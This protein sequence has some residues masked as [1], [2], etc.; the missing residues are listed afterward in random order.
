MKPV[1]IAVVTGVLLSTGP[2][3]AQPE[4]TGLDPDTASVVA[5][6]N[7]FALHLYGRLAE[8]EGNLFF[9]PYSLTTALAMTYAG[10]RGETATQMATT[11]NFTLEPNRLHPAFSRLR[12]HIEA[13]GAEN[14]TPRGYRLQ[15]ANHLWGQK[16][17]GFLPDFVRIA[18][19]SY[20]GGLR[21]VDF[22][23][24]REAARRI[25][26]AWAEEQTQG[27]IKELIE[28]D[29]L[30]VDTRL[31]LTNAIYFKAPWRL[32]FPPQQTADGD[33]T[34]ANGKKAGVKLMRGKNRTNYL[35]G[36]GFEALELLYE[37]RDLS[38]V[39]LLPD[40]ADG[41][42]AFEK[43]LTAAN[44]TRWLGELA[45][46]DHEVD[47]TL[48]KF[49]WTSE[50]ML[51]DVLAAMGMPT[52]FDPRKANFSGMADERLFLS[53]VV[54]QAF[55]DVNEAGT[56][57]AASTAVVAERASLPRPATFRADHPFVYFVRHNRTGAI[58]FLGRVVN[59]S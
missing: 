16:D 38:M 59:P 30:T 57:A 41:L 14:P 46:S 26:N 15:I 42:P 1:A 32:P 22:V 40:K 34:T 55:V 37:S 6:G 44:L 21:E 53:H 10:A 58:L 36:D 51:K 29:I 24:A 17:F 33:F 39:V 4:R 13:A 27:K 25:I 7:A 8:R 43:S 54:H 35:K 45:W 3:A 19:D 48:P 5:G 20:G 28:P 56:E 49:T 23:R 50:F 2:S 12:S 31:V 9:S 52:A 18:A 11:L 47:V